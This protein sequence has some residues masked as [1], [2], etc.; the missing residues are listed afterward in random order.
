MLQWSQCRGRY[1]HSIGHTLM[2]NALTR[3]SV[4]RS[5]SN[6]INAYPCTFM[7]IHMRVH[8]SVRAY[9]PYACMRSCAVLEDGW[10][11]GWMVGFDNLVIIAVILYLSKNFEGLTRLGFGLNMENPPTGTPLKDAPSF[12]SYMILSVF[13]GIGF[14]EWNFYN[15]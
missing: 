2:K 11:D 10:R 7:H 3:T 15:G 12:I 5:D 6:V 13:H 4:L 8:E 1:L 9:M 14:E